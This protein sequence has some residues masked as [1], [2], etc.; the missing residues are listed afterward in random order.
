MALRQLGGDLLERDGDLRCSLGRD[1]LLG[2]RG[3]LVSDC[4]GLL[5]GRGTF[6]RGGD[7]L[8]DGDGF[9][10]CRSLLR[11]GGGFCW[12][13]RLFGGGGGLLSWWHL[14]LLRRASGAETCWLGSIRTTPPI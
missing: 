12:C 14:Y 8:G 3:A 7:L 9:R 1:R 11:D 5:C 13:Q 2:W 4:R 10:S 6:D